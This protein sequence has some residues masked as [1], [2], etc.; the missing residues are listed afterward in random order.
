MKNIIY[1]TGIFLFVFTNCKPQNEKYFF[2]TEVEKKIHNNNQDCLLTKKQGDNYIEFNFCNTMSY[3]FENKNE[4]KTSNK[5]PEN[6]VT[7]ESILK[8]KYT[9]L[10][11][12]E[13]DINGKL[14]IYKAKNKISFINKDN[15][16]NKHYDKFD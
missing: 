8:N 16:S 12:V 6:I 11:I 15:N 7:L 10:N 14:I 9:Y 2:F 4:V 1:I 13:K 3:V 5:L